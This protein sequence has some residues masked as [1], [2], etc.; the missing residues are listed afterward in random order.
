MDAED[1]LPNA[2]P[3]ELCFTSPS[4][5]TWL[6]QLRIGDG[7]MGYHATHRWAPQCGSGSSGRHFSRFYIQPHEAKG[8]VSSTYLSAVRVRERSAGAVAQCSVLR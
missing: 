5:Y 4:D 3:S 2:R 1:P 8:W 7:A 6:C